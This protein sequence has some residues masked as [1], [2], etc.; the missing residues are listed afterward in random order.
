MLGKLIFKCPPSK[1]LIKARASSTSRIQRKWRQK[2]F[3]LQMVAKVQH[4][5]TCISH[6]FCSPF[7]LQFLTEVSL[8]AVDFSFLFF[9]APGAG[10]KTE[11]KKMTVAEARP[12]MEESETER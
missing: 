2:Y 8:R 5:R 12:I 4:C 10:K 9:P 6:I 11:R 7:A 3:V 1:V